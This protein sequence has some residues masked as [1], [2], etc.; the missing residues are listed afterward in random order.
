MDVAN[1]MVLMPTLHSSF[2]RNSTTADMAFDEKSLLFY[3][4]VEQSSNAVVITDDL[5]RIVYVNN[6]F[7]Q[8]SG[9]T[10][11][12]I[13]GKN[14]SILRTSKIPAKTYREMHS[15]LE[16]KQQW[17]GELINCYRHGREYTEEIVIS[18]ITNTSGDIVYFFA[19][20]KDITVQKNAEKS[21]QKLRYFD[22]LTGVSNRD[23]FI[24]EIEKL[25]ELPAVK[26]NY[27]SVLF[28][29]LN[30]FKELNDTYGH[31]AGDIALRNTAE[32]IEKVIPSNDFLARLG[33][34]E[35]V[36]VHNK[37]S[38]RSTVELAN[39]LIELFHSPIVIDNQEHFLSVSIGSALWPSD[40]VTIRQILSR[41][42]LAMS[43]GKMVNRSY[44]SYTKAIGLKFSREFELARK[45]DLAVQKKQFSLVYQPKVDLTTGC[46]RGMEALLR[47]NDPEFGRLSPAEF[48][49]IAEKYKKMTSIGK[50]VVTEVC[51]QLNHW[52]FENKIFMDE[53]RLT[54]Q[55]NR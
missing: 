24:E 41:A 15:K 8:I 19:E 37:A 7:E 10:S 38:M 31:L 52:K 13:L 36:I 49:P 46:I 12:E 30:R 2:F 32:R 53:L 23:F 18:P 50:W 55:Y 22:N 51:Q 48:I 26:E 35:F 47:W 45:L 44:T 14:L 1:N 5:K 9:Y 40:G 28:I 33:G 20:T 39:K 4:I 21:I 43:N 16:A 11:D 25:A 29:G 27:F 17:R 34:D 54:S 42:D 6:K 3:L